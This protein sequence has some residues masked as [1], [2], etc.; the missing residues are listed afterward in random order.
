MAC[1]GRARTRRPYLRTDLVA[2]SVQSHNN[3][4]ND[5]HHAL[6]YHVVGGILVMISKIPGVT[7][8]LALGRS[9][10]GFLGGKPLRTCSHEAVEM[11]NLDV[12]ESIIA[13]EKGL[14]VDG[15]QPSPGSG[16]GS[17]DG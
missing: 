15:Y 1:L 2:G 9:L 11:A 10:Q 4:N 8:G 16:G 14:K 17:G 7:D 12:I 13:Q 6:F 3:H 5:Q